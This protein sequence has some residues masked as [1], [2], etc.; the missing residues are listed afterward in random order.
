MVPATFVLLDKLPLTPNG[1]IDQR[2]Y[3]PRL[4]P[5]AGSGSIY[6]VPRTPTEELVA[7]I[8]M[9]DSG[10]RAVGC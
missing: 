6:V 7:G 2:L 5:A 3:S 9:R 1:K 4:L 8:W 10:C